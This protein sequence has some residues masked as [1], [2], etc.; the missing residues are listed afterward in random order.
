[1]DTVFKPWGLGPT[2]SSAVLYKEVVAARSHAQA[3]L[4]TS[5]GIP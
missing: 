3:L 4:L 5:E 1:M 2:L